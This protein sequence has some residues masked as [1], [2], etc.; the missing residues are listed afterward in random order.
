MVYS[1]AEVF[2]GA[3][4]KTLCRVRDKC[5]LYE[6][7][8]LERLFLKCFIPS[9]TP[10]VRREVFEWVG[11]FEE[12]RD[13]EM[14]EDWAMW[15]RIAACWKVGVVREPLAKYRIHSESI[16]H[17]ARAD[18][19]YA[20]KRKV[21]EQA[22]AWKPDLLER[23]RSR[24]LAGIAISTGLRHLKLG[25]KRDAR[26]MFAEAVRERPWNP[27]T[28]CYLASTCL[29]SLLLNGARGWREAS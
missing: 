15:L 24:V 1:D 23:I 28:Y 12:S 9:A 2:D 27:L 7:D 6:G 21:I 22:V 5:R 18:A 11:V 29:P 8:V 10:M 14:A 26:R 16:T 13:F 17:R 3:T 25:N 4:G 20:S 19:L